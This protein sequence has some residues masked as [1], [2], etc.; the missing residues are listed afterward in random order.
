MVEAWR[1]E[2]PELGFTRMTV[3][4][5]AGGEGDAQSGMTEGW[6]LELAAELYPTWL[7]RSYMSGALIDMEELL[8]VLHTLV[9]R[10]KSLRI[11]SVTVTASPVPPAPAD[12]PQ[13]LLEAAT[14]VAA[15]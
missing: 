14:E 4:E 13:E 1:G 11:P 15:D 3:G 10:G 7:G 6:D 9:K 12:L 2:H 8:D 5:C